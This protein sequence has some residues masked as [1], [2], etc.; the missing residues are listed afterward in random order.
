MKT[1]QDFEI[2]IRKVSIATVAGNIKW[3][4]TGE[5]GQLIIIEI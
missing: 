5:F 1:T 2:S 3:E 4:E